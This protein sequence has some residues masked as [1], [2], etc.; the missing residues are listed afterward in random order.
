MTCKI[1]I[2]IRFQADSNRVLDLK[3]GFVTKLTYSLMVVRKLVSDVTVG[4][5][6]EDKKLMHMKMF[7]INTM[8]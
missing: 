4:R 8:I 1:I 7:R 3:L 2:T 5:R 6:I